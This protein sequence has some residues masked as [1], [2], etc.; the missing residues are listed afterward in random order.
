MGLISGVRD[1][2]GLDIGT[3]ALRAVQLKG[4]GDVKSLASYGYLPL[5][6]NISQ[7]DAATDKQKLSVAIK[8][9]LA[10]SKISSKNVAVGLPSNKVFTTLVEI[11]KV[12]NNEIA[13]AIKLQADSIIPTPLDESKVDW[14]VIGESQQN[15]GRIEVLLTSVTN[16]YVESRLDTLESLG[17][18]VIAF[19][20]ENIAICRSLVAPGSSGMIM[21]IDI[22][23]RSTDVVVML[24]GIPRLTRSIAVGQEAIIKAAMQNLSI[25]QKQA[26]QFVGKFGLSKEKLEGQVHGAIIGTV[27]A[28]VGDIEKSIKF[29]KL[30]YPQAQFERAIVSGGAST[31]P[32]FPLYIANKLGVSVE[33]GNSWRNISFAS[34]MQNDLLA[35]SSHFGVAA[36]LAERKE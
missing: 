13:S 23:D 11:D 22:G 36:G 29:V 26:A 3:S 33:I 7:S 30:K 9:L 20:P 34:E 5:E 35:V 14:T 10:N 17:L 21:V 19:E 15:P 8:Q 27:D 28:L 4:E 6:L 31:L 12:P 32:E 1:F 16:E 18:N 25:D 2:F 24:G